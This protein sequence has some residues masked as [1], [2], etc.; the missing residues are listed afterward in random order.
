LTAALIVLAGT[1]LAVAQRDPA[2]SGA[3]DEAFPE[4]YYAAGDRVDVGVPVEGDVVLAGREVRI[5][6]TVWGDVLAAGWRVSFVGETP[7]DVRMAGWKVDVDGIV[8]GDLTAAGADVTIGPHAHVNGRAWLTGQTVTVHGTFERQLGI[9]GAV[10]RLAGELNQPVTIVAEKLEILP[11]A[12]VRA[13]LKYKGPVEADIAPGAIV[14][15]PIAYERISQQEAS[16]ARSLVGVSSVLFATHVLVAGLL[17]LAV[18]PRVASAVVGTMRETPGRSLLVGGALLVMIPM[19][20]MVLLISVIGIPLGLSVGAIYFVALFLGVVTTAFYVGEWEARLINVGPMNSRRQRAL[21]L[22][23]GVLTLAVLRS[24]PVLGSL[25]VAGGIL[26]G[27][28]AV[29]VSSYE[30]FRAVPS[31]SPV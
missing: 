23:A 7:D 22:L 20:V 3:S 18:A 15:G 31:A 29:C 1:A 4:N 5:S 30:V 14:A 2:V 16:N 10:V 25:V 8:N 24:V 21:L 11:T 9:A 17:L 28:G 27:L 6:K 12:R 26:F 13:P 19:L